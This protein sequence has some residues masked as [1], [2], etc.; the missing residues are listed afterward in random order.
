MGSQ[1]CLQYNLHVVIHSTNYQPPYHHCTP[2]H[3]SAILKVF[4]Q[5]NHGSVNKLGWYTV[6]KCKLSVPFQFSVIKHCSNRVQLQTLFWTDSCI[7]IYLPFLCPITVFINC[8]QG[9]LHIGG[10]PADTGLP[11]TRQPYIQVTIY[12]YIVTITKQHLW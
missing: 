3:G 1:L 4:L 11:H 7:A 2:T 12:Y 9:L 6:C 10:C 8:Y 5:V